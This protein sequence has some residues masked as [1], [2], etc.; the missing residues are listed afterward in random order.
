MRDVATDNIVDVVQKAKASRAPQ[1]R[2]DLDSK[3]ESVFNALYISARTRAPP[4]WIDHAAARRCNRH[5]TIDINR[6]QF[7]SE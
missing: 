1:A 7:A 3:S 4:R 5:F 2:P 6:Y